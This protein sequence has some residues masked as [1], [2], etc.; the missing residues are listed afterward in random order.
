MSLSTKAVH[1]FKWS[2]VEKLGHKVLSLIVLTIIAR[3]LTPED[4]GI[5]SMTAIF[6]AISTTI[7]DGGFSS[8]IIYKKNPS[9]LDLST[10]FVFNLLTGISLYFVLFFSAPVIARFYNNNNLILVIRILSFD[11]IL[12]AFGLV[13]MAL[14]QK[15]LNFKKIAQIN[16]SSIIFSGTLAIIFALLNYG[17][18]ALVIQQ[19]AMNFSRVV[20]LYVLSKRRISFNF[21]IKSFKEL[22]N[23]GFF[24]T[25][26]SVIATLFQNSYYVIIGKLFSAYDLG[27]YYQGRK[28]QETS[29]STFNSVISRII[30]PLFSKIN[31]DPVKL[32]EKYKEFIKMA[33]YI[34]FPFVLFMICAAK[35]LFILLLTEK[36]SGSIIYFQLLCI[37]ALLLPLQ[38]MNL[39]ILKVTG[40]TKLFFYVEISNITVA[41]ITMLIGLI[42]GIMGLVISQVIYACIVLFINSFF[43]KK[44]INYGILEQIMDVKKIFFIGVLAFSVAYIIQYWVNNYY[45]ILLLQM[46]VFLIIYILLSKLLCSEEYKRVITIFKK[47]LHGILE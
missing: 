36:W 21:S 12:S 38:T 31:N 25:L 19:L 30:F 27:I 26:S 7:V 34:Y 32:K 13:A 1:S 45:L 17:F 5:I 47:Q 3:I 40:K 16:I 37:G 4:F 10:V 44:I 33:C 39:G 9:E 8:A 28:F 14:M 35:T 41:V 46:I 2:L 18:W 15:E 42:W 11:F 23:Y 6:I 43:T 20:L 24:L 22:F 29:T